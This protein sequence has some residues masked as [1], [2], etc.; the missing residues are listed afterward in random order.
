MP[1]EPSSLSAYDYRHGYGT[2]VKV[3]ELNSDQ[4]YD[5][6][7]NLLS[8]PVNLPKVN[9]TLDRFGPTK[10][11]TMAPE[12]EDTGH[13]LG[14]SMDMSHISSAMFYFAFSELEIATQHRSKSTKPFKVRSSHRLKD[15]LN[16]GKNTTRYE[17]FHYPKAG[18]QDLTEAQHMA[19]NAYDLSMKLTSHDSLTNC[20]SEGDLVVKYVGDGV[21]SNS[22]VPRIQWSPLTPDNLPQAR[23]GA[24]TTLPQ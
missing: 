21:T 17:I 3:L 4:E 9:C 11:K 1:Q 10:S 16:V 19:R 22:N 24:S 12:G 5:Y 7:S 15:L 20:H 6:A 18:S 2:S 8:H 23:K 13:L 14:T